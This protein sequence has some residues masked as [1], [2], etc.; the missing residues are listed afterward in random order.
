MSWRVRR[1]RMHAF[2]LR[3]ATQRFDQQRGFSLIELLVAVLVMG[4]GVLGVAGLQ[5]LS[6]QDNRGALTR[7]EAVNLAWDML[8]RIR[9]N[10]G[11]R[12]AY[13]E[14]TFASTLPSATVCGPRDCDPAAMAAYDVR[15]WKCQL[16]RSVDDA[17]CADWLARVGLPGRDMAAGLPSGAGAVTVQGDA[18]QVSVR[19]KET[20]GQWR[21]VVIVARV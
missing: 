16:G 5:L 13:A 4:V 21:S 12:Q 14:V 9:A 20:S 3:L 19:W 18:V 1:H 8:D 17:V 11:G 7:V 15:S 10:P 6:L 2:S